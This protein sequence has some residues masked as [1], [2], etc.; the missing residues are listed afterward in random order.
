[1]TSRRFSSLGMLE[2][3]PAADNPLLYRRLSAARLTFRG[4]EPGT[5]SFPA[6]IV[7]IRDVHHKRFVFQPDCER[8]PA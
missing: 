5:L 1:M 8:N 2:R 4:H 3:M 7:P 6:R